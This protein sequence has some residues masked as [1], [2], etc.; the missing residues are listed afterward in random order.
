MPSFVAGCRVC[1][2]STSMVQRDETIELATMVNTN[3]MALQALLLGSNSE[4]AFDLLKRY[5]ND[6]AIAEAD[7]AFF[8]FAHPVGL[9]LFRFSFEKKVFA[10]INGMDAAGFHYAS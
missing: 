10:S 3:G 9:T 7:A 6:E 2:L 4:V 5:F 8:C 1:S